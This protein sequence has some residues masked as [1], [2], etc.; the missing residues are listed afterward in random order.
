VAKTNESKIF[1]YTVNGNIAEYYFASSSYDKDDYIFVN[2]KSKNQ[3]SAEEAEYMQNKEELNKQEPGYYKI[4][5]WLNCYLEEDFNECC[6][7]I[8]DNPTGATRTGTI[9][10]YV[11]CKYNNNEFTV[12]NK[13]LTVTQE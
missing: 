8:Q 12:G 4:H 5:F 13:V 6:V 3:I 1:N 2:G 7:S 11:P 9:E 10:Y